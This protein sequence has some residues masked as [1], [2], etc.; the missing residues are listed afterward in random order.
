MDFVP[1]TAA[2]PRGSLD[3][4]APGSRIGAELVEVRGW[5]ADAWGST[6]V[7]LEVDGVPVGRA[8]LGLPRPDVAAALGSPAVSLCGWECLLDLQTLARGRAEVCLAAFARDDAGGRFEIGRSLVRVAAGGESAAAPTLGD[9]PPLPL[10][11]QR[12]AR[13]SRIHG[14]LRILAVT[15]NFD[16]GGSQLLLRERLGE[17]V[18]AGEAEAV[19]LSPS[20]GPLRASFEALGA[21]CH[22][23]GTLTPPQETQ[24]QARLAELVAWSRPQ[25]FDLVLANTIATSAAI[26]LAERLELPSVWL[27]YEAPVTPRHLSPHV[28]LRWPAYAQGQAR[29]ALAVCP[30]MVFDSDHVRE[31]YLGWAPAERLVTVPGAVDLAAIARFRSSFRRRDQRRAHGIPDEAELVLGLGT[32]FVHKGAPLLVQCFAAIAGERPQARLALVGARPD[33]LAAAV[34]R[35]V[36]ECGLGGRV[37]VEPMGD[38]AYDWLAMAD[39][40]VCNSDRESMPRVV[41]EAMAFEVPVLATTVGDVPAVIDDGESGW[42]IPHSDPAALRRGLRRALGA[43]PEERRTIAAAAARRV[44]ARDAPLAAAKFAA[45]LRAALEG[46][47]ST[48]CRQPA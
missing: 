13:P 32:L 7:E 2:T 19:V 39:L 27:L 44:A 4:P 35:H 45:V 46:R 42:L 41:L 18:A 5:A 17:L 15:H 37:R 21:R 31:R 3:V 20:D 6:A 38:E 40:M 30:A 11:S 10:P 48:G 16:R 29:R 24:Y 25:G 14:A 9:P 26:D 28:S 43:N 36:A 8:Q 12:P 23:T 47:P 33:Q 22:L 1:S 34:E